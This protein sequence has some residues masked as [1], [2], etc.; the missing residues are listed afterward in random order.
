MASLVYMIPTT[1]LALAAVFL[2]CLG[3]MHWF[4]DNEIL[5][6]VMPFVI[7][8]VETV[9]CWIFL[10]GICVK[11]GVLS[12]ISGIPAVFGF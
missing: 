5:L 11:L 12:P 3:I 9:T 10:Y 7:S 6:L 1:I 2:F 8:L 4:S